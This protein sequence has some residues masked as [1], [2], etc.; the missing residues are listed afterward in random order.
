MQRQI[1]AHEKNI[2][3]A[4][5]TEKTLNIWFEILCGN[6][7]WAWQLYV[8][9]VNHHIN[10]GNIFWLLIDF[11]STFYKH[12]YSFTWYLATIENIA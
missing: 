5:N 3:Q 10:V 1:F 4:S 6:G 8:D 11:K 12:Q 7:Q 2:D 9:I